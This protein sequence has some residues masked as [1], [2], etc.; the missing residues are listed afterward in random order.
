MTAELRW[1]PML[2]TQ[3]ALGSSITKPRVVEHASDLHMWEVEAGGSKG[4]P[5]LHSEF[6]ASLGCTNPVS[7]KF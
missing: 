4:H 2:D 5:L 7:T 1:G 6:K 3:Y